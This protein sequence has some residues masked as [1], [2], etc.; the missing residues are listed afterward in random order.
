MAS[1]LASLLGE[2]R[3][4]LE[5]HRNRPFLEAT[6]AACAIVA[7]ADGEISFG[8]RI[9][10]DQIL[11]ALDSL[12]VFD[13]HE[14]VDLFNKFANAILSTPK[15]GRERAIAT[16]KVVSD[17]PEKSALL[18][19]IFMAICEIGETKSLVKQ[20]EVVMLCGLLG[21]EPNDFGLYVDDSAESLLRDS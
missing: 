8:E 9:R 4:Q 3:L 21:I 7:A 20:I 6:M 11:D 1:F 19:R 18:M 12:K 17:D 16:L 15:E 14:A 10:T 5:R 13:S 2:Y